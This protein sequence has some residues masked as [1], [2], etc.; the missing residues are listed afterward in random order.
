[1]RQTTYTL[2][3]KSG[4][5]NAHPDAH[6]SNYRLLN[7]TMRGERRGDPLGGMNIQVV[8]GAPDGPRFGLDEDVNLWLPSGWWVTFRNQFA[9]APGVAC[10]IL[11]SIVD[12]LAAVTGKANE[13][14]GL[15]AEEVTR[16]VFASRFDGVGPDY[17]R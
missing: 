15:A 1:M 4:G 8:T 7:F 14:R 17:W 6:A 12:Q 13:A 9:D 2:I 16:E 5:W 10:E 3:P 11:G